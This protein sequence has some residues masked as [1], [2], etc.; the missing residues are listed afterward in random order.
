MAHEGDVSSCVAK[1]IHAFTDGLN[2][3]KRL[4]ERRRRKKAKKSRDKA[5]KD[6][7]GELQLSKSLRRGPKELQARY[8]KC[9]TQ[10]GESFAKGDCE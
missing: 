2:I 4:R 7:G 1:L 10:K 8:V 6:D 5:E 3:F 9:Y